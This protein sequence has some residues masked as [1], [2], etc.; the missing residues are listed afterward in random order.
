MSAT[1]KK[2]NDPDREADAVTHTPLNINGIRIA[3]R[4]NPTRNK[5]KHPIA[6]WLR[7]LEKSPTGEKK[8]GKPRWRTN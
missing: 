4:D 8:T 7:D 1:P 2:E 6:H 3:R 5:P